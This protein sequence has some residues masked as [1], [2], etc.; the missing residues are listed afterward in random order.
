[1]NTMA[2]KSE[3]KKY[4]E[5]TGY[6]EEDMQKF[7]DDLKETNNKVAHLAKC[8]L[9]WSDMNMI[10]ISKIPTQK[11]RDLE[12]RLKMEEEEKARKAKEEA[13]QKTVNMT[14]EQRKELL[15]SKIDKNELLT[16]DE[17]KYMCENLAISED[18]LE[19]SDEV[20]SICELGG[21]Y[22]AIDWKENDWSVGEYTEQ[23]YEVVKKESIVISKSVIYTMKGGKNIG[24]L[25]TSNKILEE[26]SEI[27][28]GKYRVV[29]VDDSIRLYEVDE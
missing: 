25:K 22:F 16:E 4:L 13:K 27:I 15:L 28:K 20:T 29:E 23:P 6:T 26:L 1:M 5:E 12:L 10:V 11:E 8:G 3:I 19:D 18:R 21:R 24:K 14:F 7:W 9:N 2:D 17:L